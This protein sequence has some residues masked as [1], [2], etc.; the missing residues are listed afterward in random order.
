VKVQKKSDVEIFVNALENISE[1]YRGK[2]KNG[3]LKFRLL[4]QKN[5]YEIP[6]ELSLSNGTKKNYRRNVRLS[7]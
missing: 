3:Y 5:G 4:R 2:Q 1:K 6:R 7:C